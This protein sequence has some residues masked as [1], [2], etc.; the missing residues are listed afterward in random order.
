MDT[1]NPYQI[2]P[3]I[4]EFDSHEQADSNSGR[5]TKE[6]DQLVRST[7]RRT[8]RKIQG[9]VPLIHLTPSYLLLAKILKRGSVPSK[10]TNNPR[11]KLCR[12]PAP[13][14][15]KAERLWMKATNSEQK[16][17]TP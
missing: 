13:K 4:A 3:L 6:I 8:Q 14:L 11:V 2:S 16:Q 12:L 1:L 15:R 5:K 17:K 10:Q 7:N 9:D